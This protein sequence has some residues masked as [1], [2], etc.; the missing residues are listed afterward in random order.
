MNRALQLC[1][2]FNSGMCDVIAVE[3]NYCQHALII[4]E[5]SLTMLHSCT[6]ELIS[7][8]GPRRTKRLGVGTHG[9][10][11]GHTGCVSQAGWIGWERA[12]LELVGRGCDRLREGQ[13]GRS[14]VGLVR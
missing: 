8:R 12:G 13:M 2:I 10:I 11:S 5:A 4:T 3:V 7:S 9:L 6:G 1:A 14:K